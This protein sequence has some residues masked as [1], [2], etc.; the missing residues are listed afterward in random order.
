MH[1]GQ[2]IGSIEAEGQK[3][4]AE[5]RSE[6]ESYVARELEAAKEDYR[7]ARISGAIVLGFGLALT[8]A[9]NFVS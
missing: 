4:A 7:V 5:I 2:R 3:L 8:T 1:S 6:M 9:A